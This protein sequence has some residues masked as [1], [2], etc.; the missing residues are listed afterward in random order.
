M[1]FF[2]WKTSDT[3]QS[4]S[5]K[6]SEYGALPVKL[7]DNKGNEFI[8]LDYNGYGVFKNKD[9]ML[10]AYDMNN[11]KI[12]KKQRKELIK[13]WNTRRDTKI[14]R[15]SHFISQDFKTELPTLKEKKEMLKD[16]K[17]SIAW[18]TVENGG[19]LPKLVTLACN[20]N[21]NE[22]PN[23]ERCEYQGFFYG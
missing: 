22:L 13:K 6:H 5:N 4:V 20:K 18:H 23:S 14:K 11:C 17:I 21:Y 3:K 7:L 1:G 19:K 10:Y 16:L 12:T 8:E 15:T 2:S 9:F